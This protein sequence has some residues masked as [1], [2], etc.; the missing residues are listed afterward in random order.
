MDFPNAKT[1]LAMII[2]HPIGHSLSPLIHN[3]AFRHQGLNYVYMAMEITPENLSK[4]L[5]GLTALGC[6]GANVTI[7]YK[8]DVL[9]HMNHLSE[10]A[11]AIGAVNTI[12]CQEDQLYGD[13][14]DV[15]GFLA[16]IVDLPL[17]NTPM[18][19]LGAGGAARA[20]AFGLVQY[21]DPQPLTLVAR[22][23]DQA[24][25]IVR[26]FSGLSSR[27]NVCDFPSSSTSIQK[28]R[29]IVNATPLGM[30]PHVDQTPLDR[31]IYFSSN[32]VVYD[33]VYRPNRT[34]LLKQAE[35]QGAQVI[36]GL[37]MLIHQA[38]A[39]Y[40]QWTHHDMP[41]DVVRNALN[42]TFV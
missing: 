26:D 9:P 2:G 13:N 38:A 19:I 15:S 22:R 23:V 6:V 3:T 12:V 5:R 7:P 40:K 34:R 27:I 30:H 32:Q 16:P 33:M 24:Q 17:K 20:A 37:N 41:L 39:A 18:T 28:S 42:Q 11:K 31:S 21:F 4:G 29:L 10:V 14:T 25:N 35:S 1:R 36:G 8:E